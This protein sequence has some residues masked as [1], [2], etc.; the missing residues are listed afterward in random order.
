MRSASVS[1][2]GASHTN[3]AQNPLYID[4]F[5]DAKHVYTAGDL[6]HGVVRVDPTSRP[7]K[8]SIVFKG[9]SI[10]YDKDLEGCKTELFRLEQELFTSSDT[11]ENY[12]I[13]R[14]GTADDGKIGGGIIR[15]IPMAILGSNTPQAFHCLR[16][17]PR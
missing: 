17:V 10:L 15:K 12:D 9:I 13:L 4:V 2:A 16:V 5:S 7:Q 11:G 14:H 3:L 1:I 8:L 6:V